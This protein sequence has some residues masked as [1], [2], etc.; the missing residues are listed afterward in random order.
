[1]QAA[2]R[3]R[4]VQ[5]PRVSTRQDAPERSPRG[6]SQTHL[7]D[8][9]ESGLL[10]GCSVPCY[11]PGASPKTE[12][13]LCMQHRSTHQ[14]GSPDSAPAPP[15]PPTPP[16]RSLIEPLPS[17]ISVE[18]LAEA[19]GGSVGGKSGSFHISDEFAVGQAEAL[20]S[21]AHLSELLVQP[22]SGASEQ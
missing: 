16:L 1:M 9:A 8:D 12:R 15:L 21:S 20:I 2:M 10:S 11:G 19:G 4:A 18:T 17:V 22:S 5:G 6:A 7:K 13:A 14:H 3:V